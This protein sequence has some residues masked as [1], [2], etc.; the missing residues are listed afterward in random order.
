M[1]G[2]LSQPPVLDVCF[3][4]CAL[5]VWR[6]SAGPPMLLPVTRSFTWG[7]WSRMSDGRNARKR[8]PASGRWTRPS[9][10]LRADSQCDVAGRL[11]RRSNVR[12]CRA[13]SYQESSRSAVRYFGHDRRA[14]C[15]TRSAKAFPARNS[16]RPWRGLVDGLCASNRECLT[17][18]VEL[19]LSIC[20]CRTRNLR[21]AVSALS[22]GADP[23]ADAPGRSPRL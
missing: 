3:G 8:R 20:R 15:N 2:T 19:C 16:D 21:T 22:R 1:R 18:V 10:W 13:N 5:L 6:S 4:E 12:R 17:S 9:A 11:A 7:T 23:C 14:P